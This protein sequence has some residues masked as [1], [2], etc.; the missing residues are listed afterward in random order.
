MRKTII[1]CALVLTFLIQ[2]CS[3][4]TYIKLPE[5][6]VLKIN[7]GGEVPYEEGRLVRRPFSW[8]SA[9]GIKYEIE[10]DGEVI[11]KG[12]MRSKFRAASIFWPPFGIF[13]WPI[14][15]RLD[16]NDLRT[17][18]PHSCTNEVRKELRSAGKKK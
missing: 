14:G 16:C 5:N 13:Y 7:K 8:S 18:Y 4:A 15:F 2:G 17:E 9:G 11:K 1:I 6:S 12:K 3:T 10:K